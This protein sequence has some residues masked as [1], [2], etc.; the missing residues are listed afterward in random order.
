[1]NDI[2]LASEVSAPVKEVQVER[3]RNE[4]EDRDQWA[5]GPWDN[6]PD[7]LDF[8]CN[9]FPC[10][11]IRNPLGVLCGYV[12]IPPGHP[13]YEKHYNDLT[14]SAHGG[15]T[16]SDWSTMKPAELDASEAVRQWWIGFDCGHAFDIVP[17]MTKFDV[18]FG[19]LF[20]GE[21]VYRDIAFVKAGC[22]SIAAEAMAAFTDAKPVEI[23]KIE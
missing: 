19:S 20:G 1:M 4:F 10:M 14:V 21:R 22:A 12:G 2:I 8:V 17:A 15:L 7:K 6:E 13:W 16:F 11:I 9:G 18:L 23:L 3:L 5:S